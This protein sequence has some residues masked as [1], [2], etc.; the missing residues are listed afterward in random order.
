[1]N[2]IVLNY[3]LSDMKKFNA[4]QY[5]EFLNNL[6]TL[7]EHKRP[8]YLLVNDIYL[9]VSLAASKDLVTK[10]KQ[11]GLSYKIWMGQYHYYNPSIG[12]WGNVIPKQPFPMSDSAIVNQYSPFPE[13]NGIQT[14]VKFV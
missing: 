1:M 4:A 3:M 10:L 9:C 7:I 2:V 14:I 5:P 6:I 12:Q 11:S 8:Q 13:V